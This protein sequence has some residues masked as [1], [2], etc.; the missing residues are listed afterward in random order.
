MI[1]IKKKDNFF[2]IIIALIII[3]FSTIIFL[4]IPVLFNYESAERQIEKK[5]YSTF[6]INLKI[7]DEINYQ[8]I[9]LPHLLIKKANLNFDSKNG[10]SSIIATENLKIFL[11]ANSLY[12]MSNFQ[13]KKIE[14]QNTNFKFKLDDLASFRN[15]LY[16]KKK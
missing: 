8:F 2:L 16:N 13:F 1:K 10:N 15:H 11:S 9:P 14:I 6:N 7:L 12:S 5:F 4:S 3:F